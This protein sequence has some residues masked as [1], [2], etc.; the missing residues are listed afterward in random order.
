MTLKL[1]LVR[2]ACTTPRASAT[3]AITVRCSQFGS[4]WPIV[5]CTAN[6]TSDSKAIDFSGECSP[7]T[8]HRAELITIGSLAHSR[9]RETA[10]V[11]PVRFRHLRLSVEVTLYM[12]RPCHPV[13]RRSDRACAP[14]ADPEASHPKPENVCQAFE[15]GIRKL[16]LSY[17]MPSFHSK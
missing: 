6:R 14:S 5:G 9:L 13:M 2:S 11:S 8:S 15:T 1:S 16:Q 3:V 17:V 12:T 7:G 4:P 10:T